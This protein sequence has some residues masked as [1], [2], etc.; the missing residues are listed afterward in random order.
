MSEL[1]NPGVEMMP[2]VPES[3]ESV[4][5]E[6]VQPAVIYKNGQ[7]YYYFDIKHLG[8]TGKTAEYGVV[9]NHVYQ[10]DIES[11]QGYGSPVYNGLSN[12]VTPEF[13]E[14]VEASYV[15]ARINVLSWKVVKQGVDIVQ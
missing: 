3:V 7:T 15:A 13:P 1:I 14:E 5:E 11:I 2:D 6:A 4:I 10:I 12:L 8:A 9:R